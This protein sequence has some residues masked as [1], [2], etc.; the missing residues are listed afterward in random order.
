MPLPFP[1]VRSDEVSANWRIGT[2][3]PCEHGCDSVI[4]QIVADMWPR[5]DLHDPT[6]KPVDTTKG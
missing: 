5:Y 4:A 2:P 3:V 6:A 1:M